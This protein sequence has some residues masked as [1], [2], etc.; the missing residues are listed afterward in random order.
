M[1]RIERRSFLIIFLLGGI[2]A[3]SMVL[4]F[5]M[6]PVQASAL[7]ANSLF[8][9]FARADDI[10]EKKASLEKLKELEP[11]SAYGHFAKGW[12]LNLERRF[13]EAITE[14]REAIRIRL[15]FAE[16]HNGLGNVYYNLDKPG[17]AM[18]EYQAAIFL[19]PAYIEA[20][21]NI[22]ILHYQKNRLDQAA[23]AYLTVIQ[24]NPK[25]A[26]AQN[27]LGN[28][29]YR[30]GAVAKAF[31]AYRRALKINPDLSEAHFNLA[32]AL[33]ESNQ[34]V[35]ALKEYRAFLRLAKDSYP[36]K[37]E[38]SRERVEKLTVEISRL[39]Q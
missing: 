25:H 39:N 37:T 15:H 6:R 3:W 8:E 24:I 17:E 13:D 14:Y 1:K 29:Y 21:L 27:N 16:A 34:P 28:V 23:A 2:V 18:A 5:A 38:Q 32:I 11:N 22:A 9:Q 7:R 30:Q 35:E 33:D 26:V 12:L 20:H 19:D 4:V 10:Q 31:Q 36:A